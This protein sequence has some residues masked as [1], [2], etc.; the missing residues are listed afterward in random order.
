MTS[1]DNLI[2][3]NTNPFD[4][5]RS[6]NFWSAQAEDEPV[7][8]SIHTEV[9]SAVT[10]V[11]AQVA[12]SR[13]TRTVLLQGDPGSGKTY[14]LGRLKKA[15]NNKAFFAYINPFPQSDRI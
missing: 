5:I 12:E 2:L 10:Q 13:R 8:E 14:L 7:V 9:I 6:V 15:L 3:Q 11:L 1:I 4:N